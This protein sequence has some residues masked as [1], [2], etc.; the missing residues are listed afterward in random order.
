MRKLILLFCVLL[1]ALPVVAQDEEDESENEDMMVMM[2]D[3]ETCPTPEN[4]PEEVTIG[5][6]FARSGNISVYGIPQSQ[7]VE[8]AVAEIN[9]SGYLGEGVTLSVIFEDSAGDQEQA[10]AAMTKLVEEDQVV[11]VLGPT[12]STEAF[13]ADPIAQEAGVPVMG[14]SNTASGITDMGEF[15]FRNSLPESSVIPG[16]VAGAVEALG[17]ER[18]GVLYGNDDDFT[19]SGY[20]VFVEALE[21]LDVEILGEET[22]ARGDVDF[23]AQLTNLLADDPDALIVSALAAEAVQI[24]IQARDLGYDGPIIGG[25]GFNSPAIIAQA[26]E[27]AEGVIVGAAW[28]AASDNEL[29]VAFIENFEE[30]TGNPPDQFATQAYTGAWLMAT[31]IRCADSVDPAD[32]RDALASI[33][34]FPSPLGEFS[35]DEDRNPVH[36]P[37]VQVVVDGAFGILGADMM[38]EE[39]E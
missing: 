28:N 6:I 29:S 3:W 23:S 15:V 17:L 20:D 21:D 30:Y 16:T 32:I 33:T 11:A 39:S 4:L 34:D 38:E 19:L 35:F 22:F 5:A 36:D 25:N 24:I 10:I 7:A 26:G 12:L 27:D 1:L 18:V 13:A 37:V 8:L 9:E 2:G 31:A 14:V